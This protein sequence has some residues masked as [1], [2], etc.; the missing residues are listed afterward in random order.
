[1]KITTTLS[2]L[3]AVSLCFVLAEKSVA[4]GVGAVQANAFRIQNSARQF[5]TSRIRGQINAQS[6]GVAGVQG[7]NARRFGD[8]FAGTSS[9]AKP[10]QSLNRGPSVTPYL[11]LSSSFNQVSDYYNIVR[12]QQE[13]QRAREQQARTTERTQRQLVAQQHRLNQMAAAPPF[14]IRGDDETPPTGHGVS[15]MSFGNFQSTGGYFAPMQGLEK[16]R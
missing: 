6:Y 10:F 3:L 5:T 4:Q 14:D 7:V 8:A 12:P 16:R 15:Y 9:G 1:M 11:G 13:F 2:S